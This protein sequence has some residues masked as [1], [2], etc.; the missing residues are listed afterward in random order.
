VADA[1]GSPAVGQAYDEQAGVAG[2]CEDTLFAGRDEN[3][4]GGDSD[5]LLHE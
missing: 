3:R 1:F 5:N 2:G 4:L